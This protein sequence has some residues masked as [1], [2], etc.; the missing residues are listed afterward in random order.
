MYRPIAT[1][2]IALVLGASPLLADVTPAQVWD[3][4]RETYTE[5]G[6]Q[7]QVGNTD[8]AG[9]TLTVTDIVLMPHDKDHDLKL[10]V[11]KIVLQQTGGGDVRSVI[12]GQMD[13]EMH[14]QTEDKD[15]I[16]FAMK[17]DAPGNETLT[18]GTPEAMNH[19]VS[20]P[21]V[22][23]EG[24]GLDKVNKTPVVIKLTDLM[25]QQ[26][27]SEGDNGATDQTFEGSV[28]SA[29]FQISASGPAVQ[30]DETTG[31]PVKPVDPDGPK[32]SF[33]SAITVKDVTFQGNGSTPAQET[34]MASDPSGALRAG[35]AGQA[36]FAMGA[37]SG[38]IDSQTAGMPGQQPSNT[39]GSFD[40]ANGTVTMSM[41]QDHLSYE[42]KAEDM[43][44]EM[45]SDDLPFPI[46]YSVAENSFRILMPVLAA[47]EE[48]SFALTYG[49]KDLILSDEIWQ[50][51]DPQNTLPHDPASLMVDLEGMA[52]MVK[53]FFAPDFSESETT[54]LLPRALTIKDV[55]LDAVG[56]TADVTGDLTFGDDPSQPVGKINGT[57]TGINGL[58]DNAVAM[59]L[60]PEQQMMGIRMMLAMFARPA[61]GDPETLT[62]ELEFRKGGSIF[63]NGQQVK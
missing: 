39:S 62:T 51:I 34:D 28:G 22:T 38:T 45:V 41:D 26:A 8:E 1:S 21:Q 4:L 36:S 35:Y 37:L 20:A 58:L 2:T 47:E 31:E 44:A 9:G 57:F 23:M 53:D 59:G 15:P 27:Q 30:Y 5:M 48:Q 46:S 52:V 25:A 50:A 63:A 56:A 16:G 55:S 6:Y 61:E 3:N 54:P 33:K 40:A 42:G 49:L 7:M 10:T 19:S 11:P 18:T 13:L 14:G 17:I 32:D 24:Q 12:E 29:V 60:A 43:S